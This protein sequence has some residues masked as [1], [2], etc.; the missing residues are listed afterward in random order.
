MDITNWKFCR[1][2]EWETPIEYWELLVPFLDKTN[3]LIFDPFF[4]N[5]KAKTKWEK[6]GFEC[7]HE[8]RDFFY[9]HPPHSS[10]NIICC[11]NPPYS[12]RNRVLRR[13]VVWDK[14]FIMLM[15]ITTLCYIKTQ[16][17][18]KDLDIQVII[19]NIYK[20]FI[21]SKGEQTKCP[22]FYLCF[23]CYKMNLEKDITYL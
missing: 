19:P 16:P 11:S 21:N 18:L 9:S 5:G 6:L 3:D 17:I 23:I 22:P 4:M 12:C 1:N 14:P 15:P 10:K 8:N 20:G 13:L 7:Y 2:D